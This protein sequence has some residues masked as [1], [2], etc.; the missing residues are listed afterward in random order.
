MNG[1]NGTDIKQRKETSLSEEERQAMES[2]G[3]TCFELLGKGAFSRVY[4]IRG[5]DGR[6]YACKV[7][8]NT[9]ML[10]KEGEIME[11]LKHPLFPAF[12]GFWT[13]GERGYLVMEFISGDSLE[14]MLR[15]RGGFSAKQ[16]CRTGMEL[17]EGLQYLH[18]RREKYLF[19]DVKPANIMIRQDG[20]IKLLDLG[21]V[22]SMKERPG[23]RA[24]TP[25][26]ASPGQLEGT[27]EPTEGCD[28]Y[29]LGRALEAML[30]ETEESCPARRRNRKVFSKISVR[31][32]FTRKKRGRTAR[33]LKGI[34]R[35][36]TRQK[37]EERIS[38]MRDVRDLLGGLDGAE[39]S[40]WRQEA[41]CRKNIWES[42][43]KGS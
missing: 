16:V 19:R 32:R 35:A 1:N 39:K 34:L 18:E 10:K 12:F 25:G 42:M 43:D 2:R 29:G 31:S 36:C 21:C 15:R 26:Y 40:A 17:S 30:G 41:L 27:G 4:R 23:S 37:A 28:I 8:G 14:N 13:K 38:N 6:I 22:C 7:S 9:E 20:R 24:G 11:K 3:Y 5:Q 33:G